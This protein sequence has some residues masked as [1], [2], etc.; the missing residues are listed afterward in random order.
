MSA[1]VLAQY[2]P[3]RPR[4]TMQY[5]GSKMVRIWLNHRMGREGLEPSSDGL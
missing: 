1:P 4:S 3:E 2:D 5:T